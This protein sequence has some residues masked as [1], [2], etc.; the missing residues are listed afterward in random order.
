[1]HDH[2]KRTKSRAESVLASPIESLT[3][4]FRL[5]R[6]SCARTMSRHLAFVTLTEI[7]ADT[8]CVSEKHLT[9][10]RVEVSFAERLH[11]LRRSRV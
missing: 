7:M 4:H 1:V 9:T 8:P 6:T 5:R 3:F 11:I 10:F 2:A